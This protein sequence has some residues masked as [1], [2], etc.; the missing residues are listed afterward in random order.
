FS[1]AVGTQRANVNLHIGCAAQVL[2]P[3][4]T[5]SAIRVL[6]RAGVAVRVPR[7]Q[8]CCGALHWHVGD[9]EHAA[10]LAKRN[11][12]AFGSLPDT[13]LTTAAGCGSGMHEYPLMLASDTR[14]GD[15]QQFAQRVMDVSVFLERLELEKMALK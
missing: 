6:T 9:A 14:Q 8:S 12:D 4:I 2:N 13:I 3:D 7:A 11:L 10:K 15:A 5:S 1:P